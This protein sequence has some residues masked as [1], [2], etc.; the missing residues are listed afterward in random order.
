MKHCAY[1]SLLLQ[2]KTN[3]YFFILAIKLNWNANAL[4]NGNSISFSV[5]NWN[6]NHTMNHL[7]TYFTNIKAKTND[8]FN[9]YSAFTF[10]TL[11]KYFMSFNSLFLKKIIF[12]YLFNFNIRLILNFNSV[13]SCFQFSIFQSQIKVNLVWT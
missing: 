2:L 11:L 1:F 12:H 3:Y 8:I 13:P 10:L 9:F 6:Q 4:W 7:I 5:L